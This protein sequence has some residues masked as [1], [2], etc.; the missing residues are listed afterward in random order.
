MSHAGVELLKPE[1]APA[2][3]ELLK[4]SVIAE[5][6]R[7]FYPSLV[8]GARA[9]IGHCTRE[10]ADGR[11]FVHA[12]TARTTLLGVCGLHDVTPAQGADFKF[13]IGRPFWGRGLGTFVAGNMMD[14][15]FGPLGLQR[16]FCRVL[17]ASHIARHVIEKHGFRMVRMESNPAEIGDT[18]G[19]IALYEIERNEYYARK[20]APFVEGLCP[21]RKAILE[22]ELAAGN[23]IGDCTRGWPEKNSIVIA[24]RK[25]F[26][27]LCGP[28]PANLEYR[29]VNDTHW[30]KAEYATKNPVQ[31][32]TCGF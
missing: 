17:G 10:R 26:R 23:A 12:V 15:A 8:D 21:D 22:A 20:Y 30:W 18:T 7:V 4:D 5:I 24:L 9:F 16:V 2:L 25:P 29:E 32:L 11:A 19:G 13:W 27:P 3:E 28:L 31:L 1:H 14:F 6:A